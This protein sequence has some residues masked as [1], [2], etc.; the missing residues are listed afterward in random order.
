MCC[1]IILTAIPERKEME[2]KNKS[3]KRYSVT[4]FGTVQGVGFRYYTV[5][6]A[7]RYN[8]FG[9]V[10]NKSDGTVQLECE[11]EIENIDNFLLWLEQGG[12]P[13]ARILEIRKH[14]RPYQGYYRTF[15][16]EY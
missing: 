8:V 12:P 3:K 5:R 13:S 1:L 11:G 2:Q 10:R 15:S 4:V 9:W 7:A 16:I 14:E 6:A